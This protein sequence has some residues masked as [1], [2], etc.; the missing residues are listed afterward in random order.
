MFASIVFVSRSVCVYVLL[1]IKV[2]DIVELLNRKGIT[3]ISNKENIDTSTPT[4]N[5]M[6]TMLGAI[7]EFELTNLHERQREGILI[8]KKEGKYKGRRP[9]SVK[10]FEEYLALYTS[11][12]LNKTQLAKKLGISRP[13]L[14]KL[15]EE[16]NKNNNHIKNG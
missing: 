5:R 12:E 16:N 11:R 1:V 8:A 15:I 9:I 2:L 10:N 3:L 13:T 7:N 14:N 6:L 4:G